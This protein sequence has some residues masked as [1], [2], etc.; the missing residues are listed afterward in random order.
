MGLAIAVVLNLPVD[1]LRRILSRDHHRGFSDWAIIRAVVARHP[2]GRQSVRSRNVFY[3]SNRALLFSCEQPN[4]FVWGRVHRFD[5][6]PYPLVA[7]QTAS[8]IAA[9]VRQKNTCSGIGSFVNLLTTDGCLT[10]TAKE[11]MRDLIAKAGLTRL[12]VAI[13]KLTGQ[14]VEHLSFNSLSERFSAIY[15]NR[16]WLNGRSVGSLSG[17]GSELEN[18]ETLRP[19]LT[20]LLNSLEA[21][22]LL[23]IGCGDF[24]WMKEIAFPHRYIG[25]DI[26]P[27]LIETNNVMFRSEQKAFQALDATRDPLPQVD[28]VL[29]RDV[30]FHLSFRDIWRVIENIR[31]SG[32]LFLL[33][34][35]DGD[36]NYNADT[37]SGDFRLLNLHKA[38]FFFPKPNLSILD[39]AVS[40]GRTLSAWKVTDLP[41]RRERWNR[42]PSFGS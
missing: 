32:S 18:T 22:S 17:Y 41:E 6:D 3:F 15:R 21:Q 26:V 40:P 13:R 8:F 9:T 5:W 2:T 27:E 31:R 24:T 29:C 42:T 34:T 1:R 12:H 36:T 37:L 33:A 30:L 38:P 14:N 10:R 7:V 25:V 11:M 35:T 19:R 39:N 4:A 28:T 23:D 20:E 16:V